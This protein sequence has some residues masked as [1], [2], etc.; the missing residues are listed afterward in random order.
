MLGL[1]PENESGD[2]ERISA[3]GRERETESRER[4][5]K[6][7]FRV[8]KRGRM[9]V[10]RYAISTMRRTSRACEAGML[11]VM[12]LVDDEGRAPQNSR[13]ASGDMRGPWPEN[14]RSR[15]RKTACIQGRTV[16]NV[17]SHN[18]TKC[19]MR[20]SSGVRCRV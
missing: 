1:P 14:S 4:R 12:L 10:S 5:E 9:T 13:A 17:K 16:V 6:I 18:S 8:S 20:R 11:V 15:G 2:V 19:G 3:A 7:V